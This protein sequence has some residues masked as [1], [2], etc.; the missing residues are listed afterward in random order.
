MIGSVSGMLAPDIEQLRQGGAESPEDLK[1][2]AE[3]FEALLVSQMLKSVRESSSGGWIGGEGET[4]TL[5]VEVAEQ[6]L[7]RVIAS[8]GGM[9]LADLIVEGL[10]KESTK[11]R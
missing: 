8:Q 6:Q 10:S 5:M 1:Q 9:G 7:A 4:G 11:G 3:E 2:V